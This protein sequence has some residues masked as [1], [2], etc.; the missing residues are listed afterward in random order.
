MIVIRLDETGFPGY[1]HA[2]QQGTDN[3]ADRLL[4]FLASQFLLQILIDDNMLTIME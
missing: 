2:A 3:P 4:L 1:F